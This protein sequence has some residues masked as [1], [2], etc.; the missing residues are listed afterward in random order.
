MPLQKL[1]G[2]KS[3]S[4]RFSSS[5]GSVDSTSISGNRKTLSS[6]SLVVTST[7]QTSRRRRRIPRPDRLAWPGET[8]SS[9]SCSQLTTQSTSSSPPLSQ[10][11][12]ARSPPDSLSG[13]DDNTRVRKASPSTKRRKTAPSEKHSTKRS[14]QDEEYILKEQNELWIDKY[15][16]TKSADLVVAP[17]KV[18]QVVSWLEEGNEGTADQGGRRLLV[19]I[20]GSGVGKS[21]LIHVLG[22]E[23]DFEIMEWTESFY[24]FTSERSDMEFQTP[25]QHW[26][27]F[28]QQNAVGY[29][30]LVMEESE[31][32]EFSSQIR[33]TKTTAAK[34][35]ILSKTASSPTSSLSTN[36]RKRKKRVI[37]LDELPYCHT[38]ESKASF[39]ESLTQ[40]VLT[41]M[42]PTVWIWSHNVLEGKQHN[43]GDLEALLEP[44]VL[45]NSEFVTM[46]TIHPATVARFQS[47][48]KRIAQSENIRIPPNLVVELHAQSRG[49]IR[50]AIHALQ[51][52]YGH[53]E[54]AG[55]LSAPIQNGSRPGD[56]PAVRGAE[57]DVR[58]S[59]FHSLGK[60]LYAK[61]KKLTES[62]ATQ[63]K[64]SP[65]EA[66]LDFDPEAAMEHS[67]MELGGSLHFLQ[68]HSLDFFTDVS[69]LSVAWDLYSDAAIFMDCDRALPGA[70]SLAGRAVSYANRHPAPN[71]FRQFS[72]PKS[73]D[74]I[75][76]RRVN[77]WRLDQYY[78]YADGM[79]RTARSLR[80][81]HSRE[82]F[83][84]DLYPYARRIFMTEHQ[85]HQHGWNDSDEEEDDESSYGRM[86]MWSGPSLQSFVTGHQTE[87]MNA[88]K[89][90][91]TLLQREQDEILKEDD[92]D[93]FNDDWSKE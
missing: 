14:E 41:S 51:Y 72:K 92:I 78:R 49:D 28:L 70:S 9:E 53:A 90:E 68:Y 79:P 5:R 42:I 62:D 91:D 10:T 20:G 56:S 71:K 66:P 7:S 67:G 25:L 15:R 87:D 47:T 6:P 89:Q 44:R 29:S 16:P 27:Q 18:R 82:A 38:T 34:R 54:G 24:E 55:E 88:A 83:A 86:P 23:Y 46:M 61:R 17:K 73:F 40:H 37:L 57:R 36:M 52:Q 12:A 85:Q 75:A 80:S 39:R 58:L 22:K 45:Y 19:L 74:V 4:V 77:Q 33:A 50:S 21:T 84:T 60:A 1:K 2:R 13:R 65:T 93:E 48:L 59:T 76:K 31:E 43:P 35:R 32:K 11:V 63:G 30:S 69:E 26:Q 3:S 81:R 8:L 64:E